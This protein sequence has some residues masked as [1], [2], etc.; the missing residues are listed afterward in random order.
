MRKKVREIIWVHHEHLSGRPV[1]DEHV[2][3]HPNVHPRD[4]LDNLYHTSMHGS[5]N[6]PTQHGVLRSCEAQG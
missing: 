2:E 1:P 4:I 6:M 5:N 3:G